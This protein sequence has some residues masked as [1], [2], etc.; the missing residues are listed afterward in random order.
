MLGAEPVDI[1]V[2]C[3]GRRPTKGLLMGRS[4]RRARAPR[5]RLRS[6]ADPALTSTPSPVPR[7]P[8]TATAS[9]CRPPSMRPT[10]D[11]RGDHGDA[12]NA[13][14]L[15]VGPVITSF[16]A[17]LAVRCV[18]SERSRSASVRT[19]GRP[20]HSRCRGRDDRV[21][22]LDGRA[23]R[24]QPP[25]EV[26]VG[27]L[28]RLGERR[29]GQ[30]LLLEPWPIR[31]PPPGAGPAPPGGGPMPSGGVKPSGGVNPP[32]P[33]MPPA[34]CG[35]CVGVAAEGRGCGPS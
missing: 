10:C 34:S 15:V 31:K 7:T 17:R 3:A 13:G 14:R 21:Q 6:T 18:I 12:I 1:R 28:V 4:T 33:P 8:A 27:V 23:V 16:V 11:G 19:S 35:P 5:R 9:H 26:A 22:R 32:R 20:L 30:E 24:V 25:V 29:V 2:V